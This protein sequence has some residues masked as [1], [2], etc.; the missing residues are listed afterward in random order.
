MTDKGNIDNIV[1]E[2]FESINKKIIIRRLI[3]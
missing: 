3:K 2:S 1:K